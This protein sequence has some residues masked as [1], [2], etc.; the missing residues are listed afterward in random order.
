M[1]NYLKLV[2]FEL[3]RFLKIYLVLIG[4][5][6]VLQIVG[7]IVQANQY[8]DNANEQIHIYS[9]PM[10][11]FLSDYGTFSLQNVTSTWWFVGPIAISIVSLLIY[12]FFIWYRDW[13]G[14][15]TFIYRLLMLPTERINVYLAKATTILILVL[16][17]IALQLVLLPVEGK[18]TQWIVP[19][20]FRTDLTLQEMIQSF[21]YFR[22]LIPITFFQFIIHYGIG[23]TAVLVVFTAILF[24]R[25]F[26]LKGV[27]LGVLYAAVSLFIFISPLLVDGFLLQSFFYPGE[28]ILLEFIAGIIVLAGAIWTGH[29]LL[30]KKIRV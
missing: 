21:D 25:S 19:L 20:D 30:N 27:I 8:L 3:G 26:R 17:L 11:R 13:F 29:Y 2:H 16:G 14:K 5:I 7:V 22:I 18:I 15:N 10:E 24:E 9:T 12:V 1:M 4:L 23:I 6:I 28:L